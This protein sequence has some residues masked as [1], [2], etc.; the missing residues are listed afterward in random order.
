MQTTEVTQE[1]WTQVM[2]ENPSFT[3]TDPSLPVENVSWNDVQAFI[4]LLNEKDTRHTY[5]LPTEAQW[6]YAARATTETAFSN[7]TNI[8]QIKISCE[9]TIIDDI[10]YYC[11]N[12]QGKTHPVSQ[13]QANAF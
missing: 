9:Q 12:S 10:A 7:G 4:H 6:E 8:S 11:F 13:K 3:Q 5:M 2:G 1:Q